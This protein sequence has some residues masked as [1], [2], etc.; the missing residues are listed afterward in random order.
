[1]CVCVCVCVW[2]L[3]YFNTSAHT[4]T[5]YTSYASY[6]SVRRLPRARLV[7]EE[8]PRAKGTA[9]ERVSLGGGSTGGKRQA[10]HVVRHV[11][12]RRKGVHGVVDFVLDRALL[13]LERGL[14]L[15]QVLALGRFVRSGKRVRVGCGA[16]RSMGNRY[17][18]APPLRA[19]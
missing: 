2:L 16:G 4:D 3:F 17:Q 7:R 6:A 10:A 5:G 1:V 15:V 9:S 12:G 11:D 18:P 14:E 19:P 8:L 13:L